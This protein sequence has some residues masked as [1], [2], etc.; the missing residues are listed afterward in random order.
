MVKGTQRSYGTHF[1]LQSFFIIYKKYR[2]CYKK[3]RLR[4]LQLES[5]KYAKDINFADEG[6]F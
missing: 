4:Q 1:K 5:L 2:F 3:E 6:R